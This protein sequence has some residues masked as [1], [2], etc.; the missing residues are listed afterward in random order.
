MPRII[1]GRSRLSRSRRLSPQDSQWWLDEFKNSRAD[2]VVAI[3]GQLFAQDGARRLGMQAWS[4]L[5]AND[6]WLS[7]QLGFTSITNR[8]A[9][10]LTARPSPLALNGVAAVTDTFVA[11]VTADKLK[12]SAVTSGGEWELQQ[13]AEQLTNFVD[14][15][16]YENSF[17]RLTN[18]LEYDVC[19][20]GTACVKVGEDDGRISIDRVLSAHVL[21]DADD[22]IN[23]KPQCLYFVRKMARVRVQ[24]LYPEQSDELAA[25]GQTFGAQGRGNGSF[26]V[27]DNYVIV[28]E[29]WRLAG[30]KKSPGLHVVCCGNVT[31]VDEP[32]LRKT[33]PI[34][35]L[36]RKQPGQ[37]IWGHSLSQELSGQQLNLNKQVRDYARARALMVGHYM[38]ENGTTVNTGQLNDRIGGFIKYRG[39]KPEYVSPPPISDQSVAEIQ[40]SWE[41]M[42]ETIGVSQAQAQSQK[43]PG[44]NSGKALLVYADIQ[45]NRFK[46]SFEE[47]QWF[48]ID[49]AREVI[50]TAREMSNESFYVQAAG[51]R[52]M[53]A[54]RWADTGGLDDSEF[55][56]QM[57]ATNGLADDPAAR[58]QQVQDMMTAGLVEAKAGRRLLDMP[59]L[60]EFSSFENANYNLTMRIMTEIINGGKYVGP[61]PFMDLGQNGQDGESVKLMQLGFLKGQLDGVPPER[62]ELI[63]RWISAARAQVAPPAPP[64][65]PGP[66]GPGAGPP[67]GPANTNGPPLP[68]KGL[69]GPLA[70]GLPP[71]PQQRTM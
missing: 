32:W 59:D 25:G 52:E 66:A 61:M 33:Y 29:A 54:V 20:Y 2:K 48:T 18:Q 41:K 56:L 38:I 70:V 67:G 9:A 58:I 40:R 7:T 11:M 42:F 44:L 17:K 34:K 1:A 37:G 46:P 31:M 21:V 36:Y 45:S 30:N 27:D 6:P 55:V 57:F 53:S 71:P 4:D 26:N 5:Y 60:E 3:A 23:G 35:F 47:L 13:K 19:K 63:S 43:P 12:V 64:P 62:L 10:H 24:E 51:K 65:P 22:A 50:A 69:G 39:T 15:V 16:F 8:R 68:T 49:V 28:V 14:G